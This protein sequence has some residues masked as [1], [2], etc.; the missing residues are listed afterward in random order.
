M[1]IISMMMSKSKPLAYTEKGKV[2][3]FYLKD[4][5][6]DSVIFQGLVKVT[7]DVVDL[8]KAKRA[9]IT[10]EADGEAGEV[11]EFTDFTIETVNESSLHITC[12]NAE[13]DAIAM[14]IHETFE[15][16]QKGTYIVPVYAA[17][18]EFADTIHPI[19]PKY[20]PGAVL[21]VVELSTPLLYENGFLAT[22]NES[23][24]SSIESVGN[25]P[26]Y[27]IV[28]ITTQDIDG[29]TYGVIC[30]HSSGRNQDGQLVY[31]HSGTLVFE[32]KVLPLMI[33]K[34]EGAWS[35]ILV[36]E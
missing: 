1:D 25:R 12:L 10:I 28:K 36:V 9:E 20:I 15:G 6:E 16:Y 13:G 17:R 7:D 19:D 5:T 22:L 32:G 24:S 34:E 11:L 23:E 18:I 29:I 2:L 4:L 26:F 27:L 31:V 35:A 30:T 14:C 3:T 33:F 21:P 8:T